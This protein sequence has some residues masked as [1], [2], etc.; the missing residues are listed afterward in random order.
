MKSF[1]YCFSLLSCAVLACAAFAV[2]SVDH[3][4]IAMVDTIKLCR[5]WAVKL[6]TGPVDMKRDG[7]QFNRPDPQLVRAQAF[8]ARILKRDT[9]R[10][11]AG[12][13]MCPSI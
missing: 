6:V 2:S 1:R 9:V 3:C 8:V 10:V 12:W 13:R 5:D 7:V 4:V 11:E